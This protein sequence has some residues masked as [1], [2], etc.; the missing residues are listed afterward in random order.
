MNAP[1]ELIDVGALDRR[2]Y[3]G[4]GDIA[5]IMGV[6]PRRTPLDVYLAKTGAPEP[7]P[8]PEQLKRFRRGKLMEPVVL[9]MMRDDFGI[10]V[11]AANHRYRD[12]EYPFLAAELDFEWRDADPRVRNG[13]IK[14]VH[15]FAA[16]KW[17]EAGTEDVPIEYAAQSMWGLMITGRGLCQYGVLF[18][19]DNLAIYHVMRD[20]ET[21]ANM[22]EAALSFWHDNVIARVPPAPMTAGDL[23]RLWPRETR[24]TIVATPEI[25][26]TLTEHKALGAEIRRLEERRD[27]LSFQIGEFVK[28]FASVI[29]A[30]NGDKLATYKAQS[31]ESLDAKA[32]K[33]AHPDLYGQFARSTEF[34]VLRHSNPKG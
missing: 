10:E 23:K 22:R 6:N 26:A 7:A 24:D 29:V 9:Q 3:L 11:V 28:D 18:G 1:A 25:V 15:P 34:R 33:A 32:L 2:T 17:G 30:P 21:I 27:E 31:R 16:G 20:D 12:P 19:S 13:E 4:G 5:A 8:D 14:T